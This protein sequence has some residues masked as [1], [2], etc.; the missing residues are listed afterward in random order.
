LC[1]WDDP[2]SRHTLAKIFFS[3]KPYAFRRVVMEF[4]LLTTIVISLL[5]LGVAF[6]YSSVGHGGASGYLAVLSFFAVVPATMSTTALILNLLVAGAALVAFSRAKHL[7]FSLTWP[8]V[9]TSIPAAFLGGTVHVSAGVYQA[10]LAVV[11]FLASLR[12]LFESRR[13]ADEVPSPPTLL[14]TLP[15]GAAIGF[16]SGIVGVGGG[17]FLSP[18]I[19]LFGWADAKKTAATSA[20][21]IVLNSLAGLGGR[22]TS[23]LFGVGALLPFLFATFAGGLLGSHLGA[24][25]YTNRMIRRLLG[26]VLL[27]ASAKLVLSS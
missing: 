23:G 13:R 12:F 21:F 26:L 4:S 6:L 17:I 16:V 8:F 7:D 14:V 27:L 22:L 5:F 15:L 18:L 25:R 9:T 24:T 10:V 20:A 2:D 3:G 19:L 1:W 11:L